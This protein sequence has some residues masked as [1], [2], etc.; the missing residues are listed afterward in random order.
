MHVL[1]RSELEASSLLLRRAY[2]A[3]DLRLQHFCADPE[4]EK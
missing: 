1:S 2:L 3:G 4:Y